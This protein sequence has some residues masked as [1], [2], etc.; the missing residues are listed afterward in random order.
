MKKTLFVITACALLACNK[1]NN[2]DTTHTTSAPGVAAT[3]ADTADNTKLNERDRGGAT[4]TSGDQSNSKADIAISSD[5]RKALVSDGAL[6]MD[7]KN[8]KVVTKDGAVILRG[9][10]K[11][12]AEKNEVGNKASGVAGVKHV[13]NQLDV[14][15]EKRGNQ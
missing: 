15:P 14:V 6:S 5:I 7:A 3:T 1:D 10:V 9:P 8:V 13:E 2:A 12:E 11:S 4:L